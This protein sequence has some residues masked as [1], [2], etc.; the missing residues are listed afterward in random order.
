MKQF[1]IN[2]QNWS[3]LRNIEKANE[4]RELES[5][6]VHQIEGFEANRLFAFFRQTTQQVFFLHS[7]PWLRAHLH[8]IKSEPKSDDE[9]IVTQE[10]ARI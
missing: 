5:A 8:P 10:I 2:F 3:I 6:V 7:L 4:L 9:N 1:L